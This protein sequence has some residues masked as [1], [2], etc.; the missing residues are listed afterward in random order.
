MVSVVIPC[1]NYGEYLME[2]VDSVLWQTWRDLEAVV[3]DDG[4]DDPETIRVIEA[5][6]APRTRV[7]RQPNLKLSSA[8]NTGIAAS[9]G[10]YICCLDADDMFEP[11][12]IEKC[13]HQLRFEG[14]DICGSWQ[15]NFG[16]E[17]AVHRP[18]RFDFQSLLKSNRM[19]NSAMFPKRLWEMAG[20][21]DAT[22]V[23]GYEDW[24]FWIRLAALGARATV[25]PEPLFLYRKHGRSMI[26]A[27]KEK[28]DAIVKQIR[29]KYENVVPKAEIVRQAPDDDVALN[30][31]EN[32]NFQ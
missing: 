26:D 15:R 25:I 31:R 28:H 23:D 11:T 17:D 27:S 32:R 20:G 7:M 6:S 5:L 16:T 19:I 18:G 29:S 22:M 14:F 10:K 9:A 13:L 2:A 8:R 30:S 24:E 3:V 21:F 1:H 12:Y 4:S